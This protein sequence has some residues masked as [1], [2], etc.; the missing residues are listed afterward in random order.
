MLL[1]HKQTMMYMTVKQKEDYCCRQTDYS[2]NP[3]QSRRSKRHQNLRLSTTPAQT[4]HWENP[5]CNER[6]ALSTGPDVPLGKS[7]LHKRLTFSADL[8]DPHTDC[9]PGLRGPMIRV[10]AGDEDQSG[11]HRGGDP[12]RG[13]FGVLGPEDPLWEQTLTSGSSSLS[14]G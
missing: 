3:P 13:L 5:S 8:E 2:R 9:D 4:C 10:V 1:Q 6:V 11:V 7:Q 12:E 14:D